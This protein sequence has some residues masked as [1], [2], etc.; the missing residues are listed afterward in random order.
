MDGQ[1]QSC[2]Q[3]GAD[4]S[5]KSDLGLLLCFVCF[6]KDKK[7]LLNEIITVAE[8]R[9]NQPI[10]SILESDHQTKTELI[11]EENSLLEDVKDLAKNQEKSLMNERERQ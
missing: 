4:D 2:H 7:H 8:D 9:D 10:A 6:E 3:R 5:C 1:C 11:K